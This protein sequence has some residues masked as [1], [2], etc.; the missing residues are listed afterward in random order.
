VVIDLEHMG[1]ALFPMEEGRI[2][3][4]MFGGHTSNF[5]EKAVPRS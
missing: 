2:Y 3:Q 4:R 1:P 5:R